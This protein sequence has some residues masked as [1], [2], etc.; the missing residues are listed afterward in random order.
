MQPIRVHPANP[1]VFEFRGKPLVLL[2]AT[3]HY[4]AVLNRPFNYARYLA[5][6]EDKRMTMTRLFLLFRELQTPRNPCSTCKPESAEY[7][8]PYARTGPGWALDGEPKYNLD[9]WNPEFFVRLHDFMSLASDHGII[10][11]VTLFSNTYADHIWAL[12][13]LNTDNNLNDVEK[14]EWHEYLT[15]RRPKLLERQ[16][17]HVQKIVRELNCY[18]NFFFEICNEP[19]GNFSADGA[20]G[21]EEI[22]EWQNRIAEAVRETEADLTNKHMVVGQ[23]AFNYTLFEQS[24]TE[25]FKS[26]PLD[27]VNVHPLAN[28]TY[29]GK[30]YDLGEFMRGWLKL[31]ELRD[32]C[33]DTYHEPKPLN[34]DEDNTASCQVNIKGWT[35]HRKRAWTTLM[36]GCHYDYIDFSINNY[37]ETGTP[38]SQRYIRTWI[39]HLSEFI[40]SIDLVKARPLPDWLKQLPEHTMGCVLAVEGE[41]YCIYIADRREFDEEGC[42]EPIHEKIAFDLPGGTYNVSSYSP[43]TGLYSPAMELKGGG[44]HSVLLPEF[45]HDLVVRIRR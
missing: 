23:A 3:E 21:V 6:V 17:A 4:G 35:V 24:S 33:L 5:D 8:A 1:K 29:R 10:V 43:V 15:C 26:M 18:D 44:R 37:L 39:R 14:I 16:I 40:H 7:V 22:D 25:S 20:P 41:D 30:S 45:V 19:G 36:C 13:P 31:I 42:G 27:V 9:Q 28:M 12:Q 32:Y 11:E 2:T 38:D 34:M